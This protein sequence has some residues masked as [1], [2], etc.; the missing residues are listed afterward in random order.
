[1]EFYIEVVESRADD[2]RIADTAT[3]V[4]PDLN[5]AKERALQIARL[6]EDAVGY[7]I[8]QNAR[9]VAS[10]YYRPDPPVED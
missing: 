6:K 1:M 2:A 9:H 4:V 5:A 7:R 10:H 3:V 8:Y